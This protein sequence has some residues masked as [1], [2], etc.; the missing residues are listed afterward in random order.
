[1]HRLI[2]FFLA[3]VDAA[4]AAAVGIAATLA[5]LTLV[6]VLAAG[7]AADWGLLWPAASKVWQLGHLVPL[8]I[9]LPGDYLAAAGID[10][11]AASFTLSLAP[12]AFAGFTAIFAARSGRR[13]SRAGAWI[14][15]VATGSVLFTVTAVVIAVTSQIDVAATDLWVAILLPA[16]VFT[17]PAL[18]GAV[19]TEWVEATDG[20]IARVRD[21]VEAAPGGWGAVPALVVHGTAVVVVGLVGIAA[22]VTAIALF[23]RGG[24]VIALFESAH[25]D[26]LGATIMTLGQLAY[27]PTLI[28][29]ALAFIAG[30]GFLI[31]AGTTISPAGTQVGV[32]PGIPVLGALPETI[33]SWMLLLALLPIAVGAFAGWIARSRLVLAH[34][35]DEV[36]DASAH[37]SVLA[38]LI[39][40]D[41]EGTTREPE[42]ES[43][44]TG[45]R[46]VLALG[47]AVLS[48]AVAALL[49]ATASGSLGPG[50]LAEVGPTPGPVALAVGLEVALGAGILL[51]SP[52]APVC[53]AAAGRA[54]A[55][56]TRAAG[57][58]NGGRRAAGRLGACSRSLS[59]SR[60]R[61]PICGLS[62]MPRPI[63]TSRRGSWSSA[64]T[65]KPKASPTRRSTA[66]RP[67][68]CHGSS[69]RAVR[70]GAQSSARSSP[71]GS[72][73]SSC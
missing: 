1:M 2:V 43:D 33:S 65:A 56:R 61:A 52:P 38:G 39:G 53:A 26:A 30:P 8:G 58:R 67:S 45:V 69:S 50:T 42:P 62:W 22:L 63:R 28:V 70:N 25:V 15:G 72:P 7:G 41:V 12:L 48:A 36:P 37:T 54:M 31:G 66:S 34:V 18:L 49:A 68:S 64:P 29:W 11:A 6:W 24:E 35:T 10:D 16:L 57:G 14:T 55:G 59:S 13:A 40:V 51:L 44:G 17:I 5:P 3:A 20:V 9:T 47:I 46:A 27:L 73:T 4:I 21:R 19:T 60:A 32:L 23:A 71:C